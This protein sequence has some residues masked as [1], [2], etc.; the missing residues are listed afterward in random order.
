MRGGFLKQNIWNYA[1]KAIII[2]WCCC[3]NG[4]FLNL[5]NIWYFHTKQQVE[6]TSKLILNQ[7]SLISFPSFWYN[8]YNLV[9]MYGENHTTY[10]HRFLCFDKKNCDIHVRSHDSCMNQRMNLLLPD[11]NKNLKTKSIYYQNINQVINK[12]YFQN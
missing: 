10:V 8:I 9:R 5:K 7:L 1:V 6:T 12:N 4:I 3:I 2:I 11:I